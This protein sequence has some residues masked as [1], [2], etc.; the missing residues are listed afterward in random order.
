MIPPTLTTLSVSLIHGRFHA[1]AVN[2]GTITGSWDAPG[3]VNTPE[4]LAIAIKQA[5]TAI[6]Y[7]GKT[8]R[9]VLA[10]PRLVS[11]P[12]P[13]PSATGTALRRVLDRVVQRDKTFEGP[14]VWCHQP[15]PS[16]KT[17]PSVLL[18]LFPAT[19]LEDFTRA[20]EKAA[21]LTL[22]SVVPACSVLHGQIR[23]LPHDEEDAV[24]VV[25]GL[26]TSSILLVGQRDGQVLIARSVPA[27]WTGN[28]AGLLGD[29]GSTNLYIKEQFGTEVA[30]IYLFG[31][32][33]EGHRAALQ[34]S[35]ETPV[36]ESPVDD[37]S[38][39]WATEVLRLPSAMTPNLVGLAQQKA[40]Q[41]RAMMRTLGWVTMILILVGLTMLAWSFIQFHRLEAQL[42]RLEKQHQTLK[43]QLEEYRQV[44]ADLL[45]QQAV[46][47]A[48]I[49]EWPDPLASLSL[50]YLT[51]VVPEMLILKEFS[52]FQ[53]GPLWHIQCAGS[54]RPVTN[55]APD[56]LLSTEVTTFTNSL[57]NPPMNL[58]ITKTELSSGSQGLESEEAAVLAIWKERVKTGSTNRSQAASSALEFLVTGVTPVTYKPPENGP[59]AASAENAP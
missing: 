32:K 57:A 26:G 17:G 1:V 45:D 2:R 27:S 56:L 25:A 38:G 33:A 49:D 42:E 47:T 3:L 30:G 50:G 29:L 23:Q 12:S 43:P 13:V 5:A 40:P 35:L 34:A 31:P 53:D 14:A 58:Q 11:T 10:H 52:I 22:V 41:R 37:V 54:L 36:K 15:T 21:G 18:H 59:S 39:Y 16:G 48:V 4:E 8:V 19:L 7:S 28:V 44:Y 6:G 20:C 46:Q 9:M 24:M 55:P 51:E